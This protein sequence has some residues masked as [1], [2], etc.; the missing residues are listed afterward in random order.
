MNHTMTKALVFSPEGW[1]TVNYTESGAGFATQVISFVPDSSLAVN[2]LYVRDKGLA[3]NYVKINGMP[4]DN[5]QVTK[6]GTGYAKELR[7]NLQQTIPPS[8]A[9]IT[10]S[11]NPSFVPVLNE[12]R[13][14]F[15]NSPVFSSTLKSFSITTCPFVTHEIQV[16]GLSGKTAKRFSGNG[17]MR[18]RFGVASQNADN[19]LSP[20]VYVV[21]VVSGNAALCRR[22]ILAQ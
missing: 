11:D 4:V 13:P 10:V 2:V 9:I 22:F 15:Q 19:V 17:V 3:V 20:G 7:I 1:A 6:V 12:K 8:G 18:Y 21:K 16:V 5:A 14:V